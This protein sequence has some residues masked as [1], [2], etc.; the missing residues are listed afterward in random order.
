MLDFCSIIAMNQSLKNNRTL[1]GERKKFFASHSDYVKAKN[2]YIKITSE[3][4][5]YKSASKEELETIRTTFLLHKKKIVRNQ[6]IYLIFSNNR[7][8]QLFK[9]IFN[10]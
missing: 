8:L 9:H 5:D 10:K 6:I 7:N 4:F 3:A 1:L 2:Q